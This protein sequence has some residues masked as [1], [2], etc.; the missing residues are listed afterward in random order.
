MVKLKSKINEGIKSIGKMYLL[1]LP[2]RRVIEYKKHIL[3]FLI[4]FEY[5]SILYEKQTQR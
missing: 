3:S 2:K 4:E 5:E 1:I